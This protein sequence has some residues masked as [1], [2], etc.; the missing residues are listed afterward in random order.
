M[1]TGV[2]DDEQ[3]ARDMADLYW[4][5]AC[6]IDNRPDDGLPPAWAATTIYDRLL[7]ELSPMAR[8]M[9]TNPPLAVSNAGRTLLER[10]RVARTVRGM[11]LEN[12]KQFRQQDQ[13]QW[14]LNNI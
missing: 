4:G 13:K 11:I 8:R 9:I 3:F 2:S 1:T 10:W 14:E 7:A 5:L 6:L 12:E